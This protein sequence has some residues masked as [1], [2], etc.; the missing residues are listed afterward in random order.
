MN[1]KGFKI[2]LLALTLGV[3]S[4]NLALAHY[5]A[6]EH[7]ARIRKT[8]SNTTSWE[9][10]MGCL[11]GDVT[12][13]EQIRRRER[14][15][16]RARKAAVRPS[17]SD[18][19]SAPVRP[20]KRPTQR[21]NP[22]PD[23]A[24]IPVQA[25]ESGPTPVLTAPK[26]P[27]APFKP[28]VV[29]PAKPV[30]DTP[31]AAA[32]AKP[33]QI[34]LKSKDPFAGKPIVISKIDNEIT[35]TIGAPLPAKTVTSAPAQPI[36]VEGKNETIIIKNAP[37]TPESRKPVI[38]NPSVG[39]EKPAEQVVTKPAKK[40]ADET[41]KEVAAVQPEEKTEE[42]PAIP[43]TFTK[44]CAS[45]A[46]EMDKQ[47]ELKAAMSR[48]L[49]IKPMGRGDQ[50]EVPMSSRRLDIGWCFVGPD[51]SLSNC[52]DYVQDD[53][54]M[55]IRQNQETGRIQSY[56]SDQ[57][58]NIKTCSDGKKIVSEFQLTKSGYTFNL[59]NVIERK[60]GKLTAI[61]H[62]AWTG[63]PENYAVLNSGVLGP[64]EDQGSTRLVAGQARIPR[65]RN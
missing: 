15:E 62:G 5:N 33:I 54:P 13:I 16:M 6:D 14:L 45:T 63:D 23:F 11:N 53:T 1:F 27:V 19:D 55:R 26:K 50:R 29:A 44:K 36:K 17:I 61:L 28:T 48:I 59:K 65:G 12:M 46:A 32:P 60:N 18:F 9:E 3:G 64:A 49:G 24:D 35:T 43:T 8:C 41:A 58:V 37:A 42:K 10:R 38:L 40:K 30:A 20:T 51:G 4:Q 7:E 52:K 39:Q 25:E 22:Q 21:T 56:V 34:D 31:V 57:W 2:Q 47:P